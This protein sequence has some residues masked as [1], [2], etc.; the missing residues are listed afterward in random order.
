MISSEKEDNDTVRPL[1]EQFQSKRRN[2]LWRI[3]VLQVKIRI[4]IENIVK[5]K[6]KKCVCEQNR[7]NLRVKVNLTQT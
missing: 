7:I 3:W 5:K 1:K 2:D 6:K 4:K